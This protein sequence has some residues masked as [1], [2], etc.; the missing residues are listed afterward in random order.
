SG[1]QAVWIALALWTGF[2]FVGY[3]TP[4]RTL[5]SEAL[6]LNFGPWEWF[7]V[8]FYA[9][10]TYGNAGHLREQ[11]C[12][13]MCPYARFHSAMFD[14]HTLV[15]TYDA[16]RGDPRGARRRGVGVHGAS[17]GGCVDCTW[18]VQV[19]PTGLDIRRAVP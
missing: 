9:G 17:S 6:Q 16:E 10:A 19:G 4:I 7:W 8:L 1:K 18:C 11:V 2:T 13:Y 3:F 14:P 15:I 5:A 12:K